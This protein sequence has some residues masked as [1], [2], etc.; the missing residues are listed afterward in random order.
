MSFKRRAGSSPALGT[1]KASPKPGEAFLSGGGATNKGNRVNILLVN[2]I[3]Q[4][5]NTEITHY[6]HCEIK[7]IR[8]FAISLLVKQHC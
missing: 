4:L 6:K 8:I 1:E 7:I 3:N 5:Q 2:H